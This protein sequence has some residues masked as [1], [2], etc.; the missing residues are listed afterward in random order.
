MLLKDK[1]A[2]VTGITND[3]SI[4]YFIA[5][6][7]SEQGAKVILTYQGERL[8]EGTEKIASQ[9]NAV[10]SI[11]CDATNE[12]DLQSLFSQIDQ[13]F[14]GLD[15]FLH[16]IAFANKN[17][18][19]GGITGSSSDGFKLALE[20]S[21]FTLISMSKYAI[22]LMEKK[23]GGSIMTLSY[24]GSTR[25]LPAYNAM[26]V[27]KAA[28]ESSVRYL[29]F[30]CGPKNIRVNAISPGPIRTVA[31]RSIPGFLDMYNNFSEHS[32]MKRN[33]DGEDVAGTAVYLASDLSKPVT[34][35]VIFV[36][37]GFHAS[38]F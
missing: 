8:K 7:F 17:E 38:G 27:A 11:M 23:D 1:I 21:A 2:L 4:A 10:A 34:G 3:K 33:I 13:K 36:D 20:V 12:A 29:A 9:I 14:G 25:A 32:F 35:M 28:L 31:A 37:G 22:P 16:G 15:I 5:K 18:L 19:G 24:I 30:E 6:Q 26:G